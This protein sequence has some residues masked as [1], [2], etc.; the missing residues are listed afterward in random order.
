M[1]SFNWRRMLKLLSVILVGGLLALAAY[2]KVEPEQTAIL[3]EAASVKPTGEGGG[4]KAVLRTEEVLDKSRTKGTFSVRYFDLPSDV[5]SGDAILIETPD[6]KTMMIDSGIQ[7]ASPKLMEYIKKLGIDSID[8]AV[9]THPHADHIGGYSSILRNVTAKIFY[10]INLPHVSSSQYVNVTS[11]LAEKKIKTELLEEGSSFSLGNEVKV[12]V[13][14]PTKGVLPGAVKTFDAN[15][16]NQYSMV[17][18]VTYKDTSFLF[19]GDIYQAT[20]F[21]LSE[22]YLKELDADFVHAPHHGAAT[23]SSITFINAVSPKVA[24]MSA[25]I[26]QSRDVMKRYESLGSKVYATGLHG[27]ILITSDGKDLKVITEKDWE[28]KVKAK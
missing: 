1:S 9:N 21:T 6:G 19:P 3:Q 4:E 7:E 23:S 12:E 13:F 8:A 26:F 25:N 10:M 18:K 16:I 14:S 17:L 11:I 20:E 28:W 27:N 5:K 2:V 22:K 15:E 24:V